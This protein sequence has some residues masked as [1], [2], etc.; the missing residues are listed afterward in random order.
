MLLVIHGSCNRSMRVSDIDLLQLPCMTNNKHYSLE[1][2]DLVGSVTSMTHLDLSYFVWNKTQ[3][4]SKNSI[5][6]TAAGILV[7]L[8]GSVI[9][10]SSCTVCMLLFLLEKLG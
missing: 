9:F 10:Q 4:D 1:Q 6:C 3:S 8:L 2:R 5:C 7:Q